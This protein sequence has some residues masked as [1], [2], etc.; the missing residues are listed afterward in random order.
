MT[1]H[2]LSLVSVEDLMDELVKRSS[3]AVLI[4]VSENYYREGVHAVRRRWHG[5]TD[6]IITSM[7][8]LKHKLI[9]EDE[10][11]TRDMPE[12]D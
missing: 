9:A 4:L 2:D 1:A 7:E 5:D 11:E 6:A 10:E 12:G 8:K 3:S